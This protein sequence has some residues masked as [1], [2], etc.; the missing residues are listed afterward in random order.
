M[1]KWSLGKIAL[2]GV[3]LF[4]LLGWVDDNKGTAMG[5]AAAHGAGSAAGAAVGGGAGGALGGRGG[6]GG[7]TTK[8]APVTTTTQPAE[9]EDEDEAEEPAGD[10]AAETRRPYLPVVPERGMP[11]PVMPMP[12]PSPIQAVPAG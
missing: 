9:E 10:G 7:R 6:R 11:T 4:M 12:I 3:L 2:V 8:P 1:G 5:L